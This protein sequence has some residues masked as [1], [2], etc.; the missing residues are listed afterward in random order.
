MMTFS[1]PSYHSNSLDRH[2][3]LALKSKSRPQIQMHPRAFYGAPSG[4]AGSRAN[5]RSLPPHISLQRP[6]EP[7]SP[8]TVAT[9]ISSSHS[10]PSPSPSN[11]PASISNA[12]FTLFDDPLMPLDHDGPVAAKFPSSSSSS[13]TALVISSSSASDISSGLTAYAPNTFPIIVPHDLPYSYSQSAMYSN[14]SPRGSDAFYALA[15][16]DQRQHQPAN[17]YLHRPPASHSHLRNIDVESIENVPALSP[18]S[19][20]QTNFLQPTTPTSPNLPSGSDTVAQNPRYPSTSSS[21]EGN[22]P[23][24]NMWLDDYLQE[25]S[26]LHS[27]MPRLGRTYSDAVQDEL[28]D[29][30]PARHIDNYMSSTARPQKK[31]TAWFGAP[32]LKSEPTH[33]FPRIFHEAQQ[34]HQ[35]DARSPQH[36]T[37]GD[38]SPFR[39][40]SP[41]H[42]TNTANLP[43]SLNKQNQL[44]I[45][46]ALSERARKEAEQTVVPKTISPRDSLLEYG[47]Q[48][49]QQNQVALFPPLDDN[50]LTGD[51]S[52][53]NVGSLHAASS[54]DGSDLDGFQSMETS[55]RASMANSTVSSH[56]DMPRFGYTQ[57]PPFEAISASAYYYPDTT[58]TSLSPSSLALSGAPGVYIKEEMM[59]NDDSHNIP[60]PLDTSAN[61]GTY[62]CAHSGCGQRFTTST[63]LQKHRREAHR[64]SVPS[65]NSVSTAAAVA[66][67]NAQP[68]PHRCMR[69]NPSTSKPCNTVFSRPYDLTRHEDT[70]HNT[71]K[72]KVRCEICDDDK[73]FSRSDALVRHRRVKHGIN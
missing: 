59:G 12:D 71:A 6:S 5:P 34:Q 36:Y 21:C 28:Y 29:P 51:D 39:R 49:S 38:R 17:S 37:A 46:L 70:I 62:T 11:M 7:A 18:T 35:Q 72:A 10:T 45:A 67:R 25:A 44:A 23:S 53:S 50:R 13:A 55:R 22:H 20:R 65:G 33:S 43:H 2:H 9:T 69:V 24:I 27:A 16:D 64:K 73:F 31:P 15:R 8:A 1:P 30:E 3:S 47:E 61:T 26:D 19:R 14:Y 68:G 41:F 58:T 4:P 66:C 54:H 57:Q 56:L 40:T 48:D 42:P 63:K 52:V 32:E 60:R